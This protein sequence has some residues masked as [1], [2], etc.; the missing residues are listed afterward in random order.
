[1][2][3]ASIRERCSNY[4]TSNWVR[5][6]TS[7]N[8]Q[9]FDLWKPR[10]HSSENRETNLFC[11]FKNREMIQLLGFVTQEGGV[12]ARAVEIEHERSQRVG[13]KI[14]RRMIEFTPGNFPGTACDNVNRSLMRSRPK[15]R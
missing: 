13:R 10:F 15:R 6:I 11:A 3:N 2:G 12:K 1:M 8:Q 9:C 14:H 5:E 7:S 4:L